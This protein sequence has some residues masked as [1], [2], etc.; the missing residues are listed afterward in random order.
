MH[1]C[2]IL[3]ALYLGEEPVP[4]LHQV[5]AALMLSS[6]EAPAAS[7]APIGYLCLLCTWL[8]ESSSSVKQFLSEGIHV[9]FV[10]GCKRGLRPSKLMD[11][12]TSNIPFSTRQLIEEMQKTNVD[13]VIQGLAAFLLGIAF[14]YDD[15]NDS[16]FSRYVREWFW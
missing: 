13:P 7:R 5:M 2:G 12:C 1:T 16:A 4:L 10:S 6:K 15:D 11:R 14:E 8:F 3:I 9:Q